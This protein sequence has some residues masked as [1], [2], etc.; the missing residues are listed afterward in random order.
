MHLENEDAAK[1][2]DEEEQ[3]DADTPWSEDDSLTRQVD[4]HRHRRVHVLA[5]AESL[6][7]QGAV[8]PALGEDRDRVD[9]R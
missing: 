4:R 9:R 2:P 1:Y 6:E 8:R 5:R 3:P 7:D